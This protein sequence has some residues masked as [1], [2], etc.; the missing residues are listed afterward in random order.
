MRVCHRRHRTA[1]AE[2]R[3]G[4]RRIRRESVGVAQIEQVVRIVGL[5]VDGA[6]EKR[7]RAAGRADCPGA[8][9]RRRVRWRWPPRAGRVE[10]VVP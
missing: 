4:L 2:P 8:T 9:A 7:G 5:S 6:F 1:L 3:Q 10:R